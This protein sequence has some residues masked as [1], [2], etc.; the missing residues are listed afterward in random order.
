[1]LNIGNQMGFDCSLSNS[2]KW[3]PIVLHYLP[4]VRLTKAFWLTMLHIPDV[5]VM[6]KQIRRELH[7]LGFVDEANALNNCLFLHGHALN[8]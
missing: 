2:C 7:S 3:V 5:L 4:E 6:A 1:M 8:F